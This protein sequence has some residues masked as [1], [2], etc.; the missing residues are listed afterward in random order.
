MTTNALETKFVSSKRDV[1]VTLVL[2]MQ[3]R[4]KDM[5]VARPDNVVLDITV[6]TTLFTLIVTGTLAT[7]LQMDKDMIA[8]ES[9]TQLADSPCQSQSHG[10]LPFSR[11]GSA[12]HQ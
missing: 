12:F 7:I 5:R 10:A 8:A 9:I 3:A 1:F 11:A 4:P 2:K 6:F